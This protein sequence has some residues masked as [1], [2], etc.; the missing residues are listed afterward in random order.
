MIEDG[1]VVAAC[2]VA[3]RTGKPSSSPVVGSK[4]GMVS[5]AQST[6]SFSPARCVWRIVGEMHFLQSLYRS[7]NQL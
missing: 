3:E 5:P 2:L 4:T 1:V 7:Q 6:N